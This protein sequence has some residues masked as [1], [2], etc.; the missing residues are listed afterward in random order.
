M[1]EEFLSIVRD[2]C[3]PGGVLEGEDLATRTGDWLGQSN[4]GAGAIVRPR[5]TEELS[6]VMRLCHEH[7]Q[8]VVPAGGLT[9]LVHGTDTTANQL[10]ISFERMRKILSVDPVSRTMTVEAGVPMQAVQE[11]ARKHGLIYAV[12]LGARGSATIGGNIATNAGGNQVIR[13]GMTRENVLGLEAV[14][15]DGTVLSSMNSLLKN[16]AAYDLKQLLIGSE[17]TLGL[18]TRAVLRLHPAPLT[19]C[20]ALLAVETF[21]DVVRLFQHVAGQLGPML[22]SFEVMWQSHYRTIAVDS[23]RHQPPL[24]G[25]HSYYVI[26]EA[27]GMD[28]DRDEDFFTGL[29]A[30]LLEEE[31]AVDAVIAISESQ[32]QA[33]WNIREDVEGLIHAVAPVA[34]FDISLPIGEMERYIDQLVDAVTSNLGPD[35]RVITFG[36][37]G[38]GNL[39]I[40]VAPRP[41]SEEACHRAE[42]LVYRPLEAIGGSLS[43]EHGIGLEKRDWLHV[44]R[45]AEEI[46]LMRLLKSTLDPKNLLNPGKVF[47]HLPN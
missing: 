40:G 45:S 11:E 19:T 9:G 28:P 25:D 33:I 44:S 10:Q 27:S 31:L 4:C 29:M 7:E 1:T 32:R 34:V 8:A 22:T 18:V 3:G 41:W 24:P 6:L 46:A 43:A 15:A 42:E 17:G 37:L 26:V 12:D 36:H 5:S 30:S 47:A 23:G 38:D 13:Y 35:S 16:N 21:A 39:H 2:I 14:L 20:T